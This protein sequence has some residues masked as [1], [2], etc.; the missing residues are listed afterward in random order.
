MGNRVHVYYYKDGHRVRKEQEE[1][2]A[3]ASEDRVEASEREDDSKE[4]EGARFQFVSLREA[5]ERQRVASRSTSKGDSSR[6]P[7]ID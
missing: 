7:R 4:E 1:P 3:S 6:K 5:G 2:L